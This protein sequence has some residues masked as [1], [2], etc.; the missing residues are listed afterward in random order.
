MRR[1]GGWYRTDDCVG[2]R[3]VSRG[4]TVA[5]TGAERCCGPVKRL[6]LAYTVC[7]TF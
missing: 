7:D 5:E 1:Q 2:T 4:G 3:G 6:M